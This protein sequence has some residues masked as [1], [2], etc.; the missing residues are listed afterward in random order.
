MQLAPPTGSRGL[1]GGAR[2]GIP[3][4]QPMDFSHTCGTEAHFASKAQATSLGSEISTSSDVYHGGRSPPT[5]E[6]L[7]EAYKR[8]QRRRAGPGASLC[9]PHRILSAGR[10]DG[11]GSA[12]TASPCRDRRW[13]SPA[14]SQ[15]VAFA[16]RPVPSRRRRVRTAR[17]RSPPPRTA[18]RPLTASCE[19]ARP[20]LKVARRRADHLSGL[21][22]RS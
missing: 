7:P 19:T 21:P 8:C 16:R 4:H 9:L 12:T 13:A 14:R 6:K 20:P 17:A 1:G 10:G 22:S 2:L 11:Y 5:R 3:G 18:G 15:R